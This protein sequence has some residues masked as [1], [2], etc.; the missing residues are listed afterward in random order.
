MVLVN[1][2]SQGQVDIHILEH[3]IA[4]RAC[5][6]ISENSRVVRW[7]GLDNISAGIDNLPM[8]WMTPAIRTPTIFSWGKPISAAMAWARSADRIGDRTYR[9][10]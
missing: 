1:N 4:V 6:L 8:S 10:L 7:V 2:L 9:D 5:S 3:L